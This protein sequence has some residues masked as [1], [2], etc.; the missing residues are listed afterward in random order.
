MTKDREV[1]I[2][3]KKKLTTNQKGTTSF[4]EP[5]NFSAMRLTPI[6]AGAELSI[7]QGSNEDATCQTVATPKSFLNI[8][9]FL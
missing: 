8:I 9:F 6:Q 5:A 7:L 1:M 3:G 4:S 2:F